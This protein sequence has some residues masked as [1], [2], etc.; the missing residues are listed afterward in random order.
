M[1]LTEEQIRAIAKEIVPA[2]AEW[3][4]SVLAFGRAIESAVLAAHNAGAQEPTDIRLLYCRDCKCIHPDEY[5]VSDDVW[6]GTGL[7]YSDGALCLS[8]LVT[9]L[10]RSLTIEDFPD[11]PINR[12][13]RFI[14]SH[15]QPI[16]DAAHCLH[17]CM[18]CN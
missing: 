16:T 9:R 8:C 13:I 12:A 10:G 17:G 7:Q 2:W 3:T 6:S 14:F 15:P 18:T 11:T 1:Q 5:M 4:H